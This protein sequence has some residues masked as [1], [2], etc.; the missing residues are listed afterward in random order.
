MVVGAAAAVLLRERQ[1]EQPERPHGEHRVDGEGV[2]AIP[3][4]RRTAR[5][6]ALANSRTTLRNC[7]CSGVSS[8]STLRRYPHTFGALG[9]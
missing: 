2:V 1:P 8:N 6:R 9:K 5:S 4:L 3:R 7:S